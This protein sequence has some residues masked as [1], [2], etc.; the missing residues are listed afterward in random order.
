[1]LMRMLCALCN[2]ALV[3]YSKPAGCRRD[4][5]VG[6]LRLTSLSILQR[7]PIS[8]LTW[9]SNT[10]KELVLWC[11][12]SRVMSTVMATRSRLANLAVIICIGKLRPGICLTFAVAAVLMVLR[13]KK[14]AKS[15]DN[16]SVLRLL[17]RWR[18]TYIGVMVYKNRKLPYICRHRNVVNLT[19]VI[20]LPLLNVLAI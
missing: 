1:M 4:T 11:T 12:R 6:D 5:A 20:L 9:I 17:G 8:W 13:S 2:Q 3:D 7:P 19:N 14:G 18:Y 10:S 15:S 16:V